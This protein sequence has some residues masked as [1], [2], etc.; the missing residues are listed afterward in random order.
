M[1]V[2]GGSFIGSEAASC[3]ASKYGKDP[4]KSVHLVFP[5]EN[6][7]ENVLGKEIGKFM[8]KEH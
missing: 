3:L 1:V 7:L 8:S 6:P 5:T 2:V 4:T